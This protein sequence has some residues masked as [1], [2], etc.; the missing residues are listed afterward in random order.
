MTARIV[1]VLALVGCALAA[2]NENKRNVIMSRSAFP[3]EWSFEGEADPSD[4]MSFVMGY[5]QRNLAEL[6]EWFY[7]V[8][9]PGSDDY[10]N[11]ATYD[12]IMDLIAPP[13]RHSAHVKNWLVSKGVSARQIVDRRDNIKVT[14]T[15]EVVGTIFRTRMCRFRHVQTNQTIIRQ[16]GDYSLPTAIWPK[17][18]DIVAGVSDYP[19]LSRKPKVTVPSPNVNFGVVPQTIAAQYS[20]PAGIGASAKNVQLGVIEFGSGEYYRKSDLSAFATAVS[21]TLTPPSVGHDHNPQPPAGVEGELDNQY[22]EGISTASV[23][24][25]WTENDWVYEFGTS[26][27]AATSR[28]DIVSISYGWS[29]LAQCDIDPTG[30]QTLGVDSLGY[31][32]KTNTVFETIGLQGVSLLC[33]S[34]DSGANG[35]TDPSCTAPQLRPEYPAASPYITSVGA[36]QLAAPTKPLAS[37]P[38]ACDNVNWNCDYGGP[39]TAVSYQVSQFTSGGGF[40]NRSPRP[41]YQDK[42]VNAYF[43]SGVTLPPA[44]MWNRTNKGIPDIASV[45]HNIVIEDADYGGLVGVGGTSASSPSI[46]AMMS[47]LNQIVKTKT[48]KNLGFLNPFLY[49]MFDE[50]PE[51]FTDVTVGDNIC[52]ENGCA[53]TC[54][55]YYCAKGWDPV[56]GL[57][58]PN[59]ANMVKYVQSKF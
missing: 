28:P 17:Y 45:G 6:E 44:H 11:F 49:K 31:V 37:N 40:S 35:R 2:I 38:P 5:P 14:A 23:A 36:T 4:T 43:N 21:E 12:E 52:T 59:V 16:L 32:A 53:S 27:A 22:A 58:V 15:V 13:A 55:G 18:V 1:L 20:F 10:Q 56:T 54:Q 19:P 39:E 48:G 24:W 57:G 7:N 26:F 8:S 29:E 33:A 34:G 50:C 30:C 42:V 47:F 51:C 25:Y 41:A 3:K 46:A 9:T